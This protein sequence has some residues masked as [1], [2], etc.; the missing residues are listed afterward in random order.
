MSSLP[1]EQVT[2]ER[3]TVELPPGPLSLRDFKCLTQGDIVHLWYWT[4]N[5]GD[6]LY[7]FDRIDVEPGDK[8]TPDRVYGQFIDTRHIGATARSAPDVFCETERQW[9]DQPIWCRVGGYLYEFGGYV[10]RGSG[11][12]PVHGIAPVK[13]FLD[14]A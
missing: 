10:C 3:V 12:E 14:C 4:V 6:L 5:R 9:G 11:C 2:S 7:R 13:V 8:I 1:V